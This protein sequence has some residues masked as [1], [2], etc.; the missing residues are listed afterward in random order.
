MCGP[1]LEKAKKCPGLLSLTEDPLSGKGKRRAG[2]K[3]FPAPSPQLCPQT[4]VLEGNIQQHR[5]DLLWEVGKR[6]THS[7]AVPA[8]G[9]I[10][11]T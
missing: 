9:P 5:K 11:T 7:L 1:S 4:Q 3:L 2:K 10:V 8:S 6:P